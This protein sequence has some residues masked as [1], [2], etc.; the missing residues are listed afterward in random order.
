[1]GLGDPVRQRPVQA[2]DRQVEEDLR[3][4][5][6]RH[7]G[8]LEVSDGRRDLLCQVRPLPGEPV[9]VGPAEM[10]VGAGGLVDGPPQV[11]VVD[12]RSR[13]EVEELLDER[14]Q[15][16]GVDPGG[17]RSSRDT[18]TGWQTPM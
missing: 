8:Q 2:P 14:L 9:L 16:L 11:E 12:D 7:T 15:L 4:E 17:A 1:E 6:T 3:P 18:E 10:A 13:P 5:P